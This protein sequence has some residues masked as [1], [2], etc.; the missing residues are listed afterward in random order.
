M[1]PIKVGHNVLK[2]PLNVN[3]EMQKG[4]KRSDN[5]DSGLC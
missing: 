5:I 3:L 4:I 2:G 1:L